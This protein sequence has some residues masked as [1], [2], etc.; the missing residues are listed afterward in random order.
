[1]KQIYIRASLLLPV[2]ICENG[3]VIDKGT[4]AII[5]GPSKIFSNPKADHPKAWIEIEDD[6]VIEV[7][8]E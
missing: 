2:A 7:I 3:V 8:K 6:V 1:M 5:H 4:A